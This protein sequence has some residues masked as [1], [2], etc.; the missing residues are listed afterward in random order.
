MAT[1]TKSARWAPARVMIPRPTRLQRFRGAMRPDAPSV[2]LRDEAAACDRGLVVVT[3]LLRPIWQLHRRPIE[4]LVREKLD[5]MGDRVQPGALLVVRSDDVPGR[6][7]L[8]GGGEH[9]IAGARVLVPFAAR[10]QIH[11]AELPLADRILDAR[12]E[13]ALLLLVADFEP[14]LDENDAGVDH[15]SLE[16]RRD[17]QPPLVLLV[18]AE[19]HHPLDAAAVV[20]A[21]IEDDDFAAGWK[22]RDIALHVHL[23][24]L[25]V[26]RRRQGDNAEDARADALGHRLDRPAFPRSIASLQDDHDAQLLL[27]DPLLY[28]AQ[29][30]LQ[31]VQF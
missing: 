13:P 25:T 19:T 18:G 17:V 21:P 20:P 29:L 11:R 27:L 28:R 15:L 16:L 9:R 31:L 30:H 10:R 7:A 5:Q 14:Q 23:A 1:A 24:L 26:R 12:A 6:V 4:L 22:V 3:V 2:M 8:V